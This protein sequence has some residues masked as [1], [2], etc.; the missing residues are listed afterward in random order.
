MLRVANDWRV[1]LPEARSGVYTVKQFEVTEQAAKIETLRAIMGGGRG[2][3]AGQYTGM[4]QGGRLW[5]SDTPDEIS[6]QYEFL[7]EARS[8]DPQRVLIGGLGLGITVDMA[9]SIESVEHVDVIEVS[10][11][12]V[13]LTGQRFVGD[14]RVQI[15]TA[16]VYEKKWPT[17]TRWDMAWF[18]VWEHITADNLPEMASLARSYG[19][20]AAWKGYW[21]KDQCQRQARNDRQWGA[22]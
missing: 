5:M 1:E 13:A 18:D 17:G 10:P 22:W 16:D 3:P 2:V 7:H 4:W 8:R 20:R 21:A 19:R 15:H 11:D 14:D 6:D 12:V 9:L